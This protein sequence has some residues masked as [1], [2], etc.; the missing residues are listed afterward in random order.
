M[1]NIE[2]VIRRITGDVE[3][4]WRQWFR[5]TQLYCTKD[6]QLWLSRAVRWQ[7]DPECGSENPPAARPSAA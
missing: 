5:G 4:E 7:Y 2:L 1:G 6:G 3:G